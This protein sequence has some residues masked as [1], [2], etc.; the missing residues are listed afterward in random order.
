MLTS[1]HNDAAPPRIAR[2]RRRTAQIPASV[3]AGILL[4]SSAGSE[5][6]SPYA[7]A[8]ISAPAAR[9]PAIWPETNVQDWAWP[10]HGV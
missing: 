3:L 6:G 1:L 8:G 4:F 5:I 9:V 7:S 10:P 2:K